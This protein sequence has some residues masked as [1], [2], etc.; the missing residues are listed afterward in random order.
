MVGQ[1]V[2]C[3]NQ[4]APVSGARTRG[5]VTRRIATAQ[6]RQFAPIQKDTAALSAPINLNPP[7][8]FQLHRQIAY[9]A[10]QRRPARTSRAAFGR[11]L[12][13][14]DVSVGARLRV[15]FARGAFAVGRH[16]VARDTRIHRV[17]S[18]HFGT[19][20]LRTR[21][22]NSFYQ[23]LPHDLYVNN[24]VRRSPAGKFAENGAMRIACN[25]EFIRAQDRAQ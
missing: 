5:D 24:S 4:K 3:V 7:D 6:F 21:R 20:Y 17:R 23:I 22:S 12:R 15:R 2:R 1:A 9:R 16:T 8:P 13:R 25:R 10:T 11:R 19:F 14:P 18:M